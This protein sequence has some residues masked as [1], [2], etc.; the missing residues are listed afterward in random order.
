MLATG[1]SVFTDI[2]LVHVLIFACLLTIS[3]E[4]TLFF[5]FVEHSCSSSP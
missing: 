1:H 4:P 3:G 2:V 5:P